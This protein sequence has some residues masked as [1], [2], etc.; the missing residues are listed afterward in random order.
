MF[1]FPNSSSCT[2]TSSASKCYSY[3]RHQHH[4]SQCPSIH[5]L[6]THCRETCA[7]ELDALG[8]KWILN[9]W[10]VQLQGFVYSTCPRLQSLMLA[11]QALY[12]SSISSSP[13]V[14]SYRHDQIAC[15]S[16]P[17]RKHYRWFPHSI[18]LVENNLALDAIDEREG[19][20]EERGRFRTLVESVFRNLD[21]YSHL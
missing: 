4:L 1:Q 10:H 5:R 6:R 11:Y 2:S 16:S 20:L 14:I 3:V 9:E 21:R 18:G 8:R 19:Q 13:I 12:H 7:F 17:R 15:V